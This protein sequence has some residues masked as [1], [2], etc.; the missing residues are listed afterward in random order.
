MVNRVDRD[1]ISDGA[2]CAAWL[3]M[4]E[5]IEQ[6]PVVIMGHGFAAERTFRLPAF[7][8]KF[9][10]SG[11]AV[12][13]FDYRNFG[14]S[15]G[16]PRNLVDPARHLEDW[17]AAIDHARQLPEI[18]GDRIALWGSSFGGGHVLI[19]AARDRHNNVKAVVAQVPYVGGL[20]TKLSPVA[21]VK[22]AAAIIADTVASLIGR[23]VCVPAVAEP[24]QVGAMTMPE[25]TE[26][27]DIVPTDS[28]WKNQI[29]ARSLL[30]ARAY[31]PRD[32]ASDISCPVLILTATRD[33][34]TPPD[35]AEACAATIPNAEHHSVESGHFTVYTGDMFDKVV[36][37]ER[38]FLTAHLLN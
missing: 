24:G 4:P 23:A 21:T 19:T 22:V 34:T 1:F 27:F 33:E 12:L 15:D 6:P 26:F 20:E 36:Q 25:A 11:L 7:A 14:D 2:R 5:D 28:K 29:P 35:L 30:K 8:E 10:E 16:E 17:Q 31:Q 37:I 32:E 18:N 13:L 3:Y 38:D 9:A